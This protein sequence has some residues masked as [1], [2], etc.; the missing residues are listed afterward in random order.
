MKKKMTDNR[1]FS[2]YKIIVNDIVLTFA[3]KYK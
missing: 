1:V 3:I 2:N